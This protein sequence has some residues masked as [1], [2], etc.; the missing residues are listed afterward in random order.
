MAPRSSPRGQKQFVKHSRQN[1]F[2][3]IFYHH[4]LQ[5]YF[6]CWNINIELGNWTTASSVKST[7][8]VALSENGPDTV[9]VLYDLS[10]LVAFFLRN[11]SIW[12]NFLY[13]V[14]TLLAVAY[15]ALKCSNCYNSWVSG[16]TSFAPSVNWA[17]GNTTAS[18]MET[19]KW[20]IP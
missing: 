15:L 13:F 1:L 5:K 11:C 16:N 17:G 20:W 10:D 12:P 14:V 2:P 8:V 19:V 3:V 6:Y 7:S 18:P 4:H 9:T